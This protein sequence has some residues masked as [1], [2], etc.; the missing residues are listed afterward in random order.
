ML[1]TDALRGVVSPESCVTVNRRFV[2]HWLCA[3]MHRVAEPT[4]SLLA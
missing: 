2:D 3:S 4:G 1:I